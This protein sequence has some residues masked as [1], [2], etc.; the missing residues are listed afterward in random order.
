MVKLKIMNDKVE[1]SKTSSTGYSIPLEVSFEE[2]EK[3]DDLNSVV[4]NAEGKLRE[5][6]RNDRFDFS[7][8]DFRVVGENII[9]LEFREE[10]ID[11]LNGIVKNFKSALKRSITEFQDREILRKNAQEEKE[12]K[13]EE[14]LEKIRKLRFD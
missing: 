12:K 7:F 3:V 2:G 1:L 11:S 6:M 8:I 5:V 13:A 14:G 4:S 10:D 9:N